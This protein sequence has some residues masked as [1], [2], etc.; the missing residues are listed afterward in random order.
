MT[1]ALY[2]LTNKPQGVLY[3][4]VTSSLPRRI[5]QHRRG[6][7]AAFARRYNLTRVVLAEFYPT[8]LE[9]I[10]CEKAIK[11]WRRAWKIELIEAAN[12][13]WL[14]LYERLNC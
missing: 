7:G 13:E 5:D 10:A 8:M 6:E 1:P 14:D 9:A 12:P 2:I 4:G 3:T 11:E